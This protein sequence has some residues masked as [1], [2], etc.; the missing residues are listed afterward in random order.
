M[1]SIS[2]N[3]D[4]KNAAPGILLGA[5][6]IMATSAIGPGFLTQ[7][8][9]YTDVLKGSFGF[10][11][12]VVF[13]LAIVVQLNTWRLICATGLHGQEIAGNICPALGYL[14]SAVIGIGGVV[15]TIGNIGGGAL[16][17]N[18]LLGLPAYAGGIITGV[19]ALTIFMLKNAMRAMDTI[20]KLIGL[21]AIVIIFIIILIVK[22]PAGEAVH[23][24]FSTKPSFSLLLGI[25]TILGGTVGGYTSFSGA[26]RLLDAGIYGEK[27]IKKVTQSAVTG[28]SIVTVVRI[29]LFLAVF[30]VVCASPYVMLDASNPCADAFHIA[31][32][33]F[34]YKLFG[35]ILL[36]V[37]I[38]P[39]I[40]CPYTTVSFLSTLHP[41]I[42][43][44]SRTVTVLFIAVCTAISCIIGRPAYLLL[45]AGLVNGFII[46]IVL[47]ICFIASKRKDIVGNNFRYP[48]WL[49][50]STVAA[51]IIT[52]AL[53]VISFSDF[54]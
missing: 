13:F 48:K 47:V 18:T 38:M 14:L 15:F 37:S 35:L 12:I 5:A 42:K 34:G 20:S 25:Q 16:G 31:V 26:H 4:K 3:M 51:A 9:H 43:T 6:F 46:P 53:A 7:T 44:N 8:A 29:L 24:I 32:G 49:A 19:A 52:A 41:A 11:I 39:S 45:L 17:L 2:K 23:E 10:V 27:N 28:I 30:G 22:P 50:V 40:S 21:I 54:L 1:K 36:T 33:Q